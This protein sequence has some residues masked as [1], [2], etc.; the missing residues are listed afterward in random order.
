M[1]RR[2]LALDI[3]GT[4]V[5]SGLVSASG[6]V[7]DAVPVPVVASGEA[8]AIIGVFSE[9]IRAGV[10]AAGGRVDRIGVAMPGPFDYARGSA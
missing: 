2:V 4:F 7:E 1:T 9:V 8:S 5:K 10:L 3:G 6:G